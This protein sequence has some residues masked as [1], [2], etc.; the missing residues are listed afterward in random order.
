[1]GLSGL[2]VDVNTPHIQ[3]ALF[4]GD[5][6]LERV[7]PVGILLVDGDRRHDAPWRGSDKN[8]EP[9]ERGRK[10]D[11][12]QTGSLTYGEQVEEREREKEKEREKE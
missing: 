1:M 7:G 8:G 12:R 9:Q 3:L 10:G 4:F 2:C 11:R 5:F 6:N